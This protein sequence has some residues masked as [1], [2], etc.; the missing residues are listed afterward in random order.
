MQE[1]AQ[2]QMKEI[3]FYLGNERNH[4]RKRKENPVLAV[5]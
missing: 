4:K 5:V 1:N 2:T 3:F